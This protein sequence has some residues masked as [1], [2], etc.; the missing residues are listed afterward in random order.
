MSD[1]ES[2]PGEP[3]ENTFHMVWETDPRGVNR[4]HSPSWYRYVGGAG[5]PSPDE[6]WLDAYHPDD[7]EYLL[8]EW[9]MTLASQGGH[10]FDI[11]VRIRRHDGRFRWFRV[12]GAPVRDGNGEVC[13]WSGTFTDID[14]IKCQDDEHEQFPPPPHPSPAGEP[15]DVAV[16]ASTGK[17]ARSYLIDAL[18][19]SAAV[20]VG[21]GG[22]AL[23]APVLG[24][25]LEF[26]LAFAGVAVVAAARGVVPG[27]MVAM[28]SA[29]WSV[30]PW[31]PEPTLE[32]RQSAVLTGLFLAC[33]AVIAVLVGRGSGPGP[34]HP[35]ATL[36]A[37]APRPLG[38]LLAAG[39]FPLLFF[40]FV[41]WVT[42]QVAIDDAYSRLDRTAAIAAEHLHRVI[43]T[44]QVIARTLLKEIE[45]L[46]DEA[47]RADEPRMHEYVRGLASGLEQIQS[48][49]VWDA[50]GYPLISSIVRPAPRAL[51]VSDREYFRAHRDAGA[52]W[53]VTRALT[54]RTTGEQFFDVT[55]KR[56]LGERFGGVISV[57]LRP[58][59]FSDFYRKLAQS[60]P[61][62]AIGLVREDGAIIAQWPALD[63]AVSR[64]HGEAELL[65]HMEERE[66]RGAFRS[67]STAEDARVRHVAFLRASGH[68]LY[69]AASLD[70]EAILASWY[71]HMAVLA[72]V[73][74]P[75]S[76][77]LVWLLFVSFERSERVRTA[78]AKVK[79][80]TAQRARAEDA[81]RH[82]QKLEA[83][84]L[85][86]GG[87]AHDFNN[88][89][90]V[91]SNSVYLLKH[92]QVRRGADG[93]EAGPVAAI[94]RAV[95]SGTKLTRQ[96]LAFSRRQPLAPEV[97]N[98][99]E[100]LGSMQELLQTIVSRQI[101][102]DIDMPATLPRIKVDP[103]ELELAVINLVV[104]ARDA[105]QARGMITVSGDVLRSAG[106]AIDY[107]RISVRDNGVGIAPE[108]LGRVFDPFFTTKPRGMGTGLGLSQVYGLCTQAGGT[109]VVESK[110]GSGTTVSMHLPVTAEVPAG[111]AVPEQPQP[112]DLGV[113]VL[114]VEDHVD[115]GATMREVLKSL[116]CEVTYAKSAD[117]AVEVLA[118][119]AG[120]FAVVVSDVVMPGRINGIGLA[121]YCRERWP[122][123]PVVLMTGYTAELQTAVSDG[124]TVLP[125]PVAP[126]TLAR[127]LA[128]QLPGVRVAG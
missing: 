42:Y 45:G 89:L 75:A 27:I 21:M 109:V 111:V 32:G 34:G 3:S 35:E 28:L 29:L 58:E 124:F 57:S 79:Q 26:G 54:S 10:P 72:V 31:L 68:P 2:Q 56:D 61:G 44:N 116:G 88:L 60:E 117:D 123:L 114:L 49:W 38:L 22:R 103:A 115:I 51:N 98:A 77:A 128:K 5:M 82:A 7:R 84:G 39:G 24:E 15:R 125:K 96:L 41:G 6:G 36:P 37:L 105:I 55:R 101:R 87:V 69:L 33:A 76:I 64:V 100:V 23:L 110:P 108:V 14:A 97:V 120:R 17:G 78:Y 8:R 121:Q 83:L 81:L 92:L 104:N 118:R 86:T 93:D 25:H 112:V 85:L 126:A 107:V 94:E 43:E 90:A 113:A 95:E 71:R 13:K 99:H 102:L 52:D 106:D 66:P 65:A 80:E 11:E 1:D 62:L 59:Y 48:V 70:R 9:R 4:C 40:C 67:L 91:V 47:L 122:S 127:T 19:I 53:Y 119:D 74:F 46:S 12:Q 16:A 20:V 73:V 30:V 18:W 63:A 50:A